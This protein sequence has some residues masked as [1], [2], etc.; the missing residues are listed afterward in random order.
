MTLTLPEN[1]LLKVGWLSHRKLVILFWI[2]G[3]IAVAGMAYTGAVGWDAQ[4]YFRAMQNLRHG[5]DPYAVGIA[6]QRAWQSRPVDS[7]P[8]H[9]P[10]TYVYSPMTLPL[11]RVLM[12]LPD[13]LLAALYGLMVAAGFLLQLWAGFQMAEERERRWL[14]LLLPAV[15]FFPGLITDDVIL[16]GN[17]S[18]I[19]YGLVLAAAVRGWKQDRWFWFYVAVLAASVVKIPMLTLLAFPV[20][21]G[22]R[23]WLPAGGSAAAGLLLF[24]VQ[25][26][27]WPEQFREYLL[28]V[29]LVF[30]TVH[31]FGFG[32][33]GV[34]GKTLWHMGRS[35][36]PATTI[37][38]VIFA[39]VVSILALVLARRVRRGNLSQQTWVPVALVAT[40][41]FYPRIMKYDLAPYTIPMLLIACRTLRNPAEGSS[42]AKPSLITPK[43]AIGLICFLAANV[44]TVTGPASV[45]VELT[46]LLAVFALGVRSISQPQGVAADHPRGE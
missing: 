8:E 20:L 5:E 15:A 40:L 14:A 46:L 26:R 32:P 19:L 24:A 41:L 18:F 17:I 34:L 2:A 11:L 22:R 1:S 43:A 12:V 25:A 13:R 21:V 35:Y 23:Q 29:R 28:A 27:I 45:P 39:S 30:D 4:I 38:Y 42:A 33:A 16:S 37:L 31:D 9:V 44:I 36:S 6:A 7:P 10:F 3:A